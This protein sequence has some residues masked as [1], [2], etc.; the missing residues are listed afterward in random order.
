MPK[1]LPL[2]LCVLVSIVSGCARCIPPQ[3]PNDVA[4]NSRHIAAPH[5]R[6]GFCAIEIADLNYG[7]RF[8]TDIERRR[9]ISA[10]G[11]GLNRHEFQR[12]LLMG[13]GH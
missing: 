8:A 2:T 3:D 13:M 4:L 1:P 10:C 12:L 11:P 5:Q 7:L 9:F 6:D